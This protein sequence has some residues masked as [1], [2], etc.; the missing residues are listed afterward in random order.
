VDATE[1]ALDALA[2]TATGCLKAM[3][4]MAAAV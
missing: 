1:D 3:L 4:A 2:T